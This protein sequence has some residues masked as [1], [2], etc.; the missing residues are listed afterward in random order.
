MGAVRV[1]LFLLIFFIIS[2]V[3]FAQREFSQECREKLRVTQTEGFWVGNSDIK[4]HLRQ[5]ELSEARA[6]DVTQV[7][8][9][10]IKAKSSILSLMDQPVEYE[11][12]NI[13]TDF[14]GDHEPGK[15]NFDDVDG[16]IYKAKKPF[17]V[18]NPNPDFVSAYEFCYDPIKAK[19][20][21][22]LLKTCTILMGDL[23][24][25]RYGKVCTSFDVLRGALVHPID[26]LPVFKPAKAIFPKV[27]VE[28]WIDLKKNHKD[29]FDCISWDLSFSE[30][31]SSGTKT[32]KSILS[33]FKIKPKTRGEKQ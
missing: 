7:G 29:L 31:K 33:G 4:A 14:V 9:P 24:E 27:K 3:V 16:C 11:I 13:L 10:L 20:K 18:Q 26:P 17:R 2:P 23:A 15:V 8:V 32:T 12:T 21:T 28:T 6:K 19:R 22:F 1:L 30:A 5:I 25:S